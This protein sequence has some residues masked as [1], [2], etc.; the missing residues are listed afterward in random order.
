MIKRKRW[1]EEIE[2]KKRSERLKR[3]RIRKSESRSQ[4]NA[5]R[6]KKLLFCEEGEGQE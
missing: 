5:K 6:E 3:A 4:K 2:E 1:R